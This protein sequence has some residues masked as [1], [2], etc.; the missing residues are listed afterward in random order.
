[1]QI[2][3][4]DLNNFVKNL[5]DTVGVRELE[6]VHAD[7]ARQ[8]LVDNL[9]KI[10]RYARRDFERFGTLNSFGKAPQND[11]RPS[12]SDRADGW[13]SL[14][15]EVPDIDHLTY[16]TGM[17]WVHGEMEL[18]QW[19][20]DQG[21]LHDDPERRAGDHMYDDEFNQ[22]NYSGTDKY[23]Y[24]RT[25]DDAPVNFWYEPETKPLP[26]PPIGTAPNWGETDWKHGYLWADDP[27]VDQVVEVGTF[28]PYNGITASYSD[29][30]AWYFDTVTLS[31]GGDAVQEHQ[32][33]NPK[34]HINN[35]RNNFPHRIFQAASPKSV[36]WML[37]NVLKKK[38]NGMYDDTVPKMAT[39]IGTYPPNSGLKFVKQGKKGLV[40]FISPLN[41]SPEGAGN[42]D[43]KI[44]RD[45]FFF[46]NGINVNDES[47][48]PPNE[49]PPEQ[50]RE[51]YNEKM[52]DD[53]KLYG[54]PVNQ[55]DPNRFSDG[56]E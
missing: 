50:R 24:Q 23:L 36:M 51:Y 55:V 45:A 35:E 53:E 44:Y 30:I 47:T 5:F 27:E 2:N 48:F 15:E 42:K 43:S 3:L 41:E 19:W 28:L 56:G 34:Y 6:K 52:W 32:A 14:T 37:D 38:S 46:R 12:H 31:V 54:R 20:E 40:N 18:P 10:G 4:Q 22:I 25:K 49:I 33:D 11:M 1:M 9:S 7:R 29:P 26:S 39:D 13:V 21:P 8:W 16:G 17:L